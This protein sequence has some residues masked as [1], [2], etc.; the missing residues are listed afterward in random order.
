MQLVSASDRSGYQP[1]QKP[2][3]S[4]ASVSGSS[5][6]ATN[7]TSLYGS[8]L[9]GECTGIQQNSLDNKRVGLYRLR[10]KLGVGAF[11]KV[12]FGVHLLTNGK[13]ECQ[14]MRIFLPVIVV[15]HSV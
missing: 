1:L 3:T 15:Q 14:I 6:T 11:S 7:T 4:P 13:F 10:G 9:D 2:S 12:K 8:L 5:S